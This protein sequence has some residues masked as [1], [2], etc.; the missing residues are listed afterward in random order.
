M[1]EKIDSINKTP[2]LYAVIDIGS[3][4]LR[5]MI[6]ELSVKGQLRTVDFLHQ[7]VTLG[8]DTFT[9]GSISS[10]NIS[11]CIETLKNF[12]KIISEYD[13]PEKR[14]RA[15]ATTAV[16]EASNSDAFSDR[17][18]IS[19]GI[20]IEIID[21]IDTAR[22]TYL[23]YK[24]GI[25]SSKTFKKKNVLISEVS[26]GSSFVLYL[27]KGVVQLADAYR[28]GSLRTYEMM[29][30]SGISDSSLPR[31]TR[32]HIKRAMK[33]TV[34]R[35]N[36]GKVHTLIAL[37]G[38]IRFAARKIAP[39]WNGTTPVKIR[40]SQ[41][42]KLAGEIMSLSVEDC[43]ERHKLCYTDA[44]SLS[45]AL[46]SYY[47]LARNLGVSELLAANM[48]MR[49]GLL[50][51]MQEEKQID[52]ALIGQIKRSLIE[53]GRKYSFDEKHALFVAE[54]A[55]RIFNFLKEEY[56]LSGRAF[57]L[58]T[59]AAYLHDI[60]S[61][62]SSKSHHK[63]SRYLIQ[64]SDIFGLNKNDLLL[65]SLIARYHRKA[66][67]KSSHRDFS[68]LARNDRML[69]TKLASILRVADA[70]DRSGTI[71]PGSIEFL[72][73]EDN[74]I[75][76]ISSSGEPSLER[77]AVREKGGLFSDVYGMELIIKTKQETGSK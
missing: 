61:F 18:S 43:M 8:R 56:R 67:P 71:R 70:L 42:K 3:T 50:L 2:E 29:E 74:L 13:I 54:T 46:F 55:E 52:Y 12:R 36:L 63:H 47:Y 6:A 72:P 5:L 49:H 19:A 44:E 25:G 11:L 4:A 76:L 21:D 31:I 48:S 17:V 38:D 39:E 45:P 1:S 57:T 40:T 69:V 75:I 64:N 15:V 73:G 26:G 23:S 22:L 27:E 34:K 60:G 9:T 77:I 33:R 41:I 53:I 59:A 14:V 35:N 68:M 20:N 58:L 32:D 7:S 62:I 28:L 30:A 66:A 10:E 51:E 65:V 24:A 37:G 16:R